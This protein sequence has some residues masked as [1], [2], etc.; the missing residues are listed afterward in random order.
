MNKSMNKH[1]L[2]SLRY[3]YLDKYDSVPVCFRTHYAVLI[4][5]HKHSCVCVQ[6][7][8]P[9][10]G[11]CQAEIPFGAQLIFITDT[12][13]SKIKAAIDLCFF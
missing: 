12:A 8:L 5:G 13:D 6:L 10:R 3:G 11:N 2:P 9:C 1:E 4:S 7:I